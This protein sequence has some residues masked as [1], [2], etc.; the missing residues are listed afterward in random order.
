M[1]YSLHKT[2]PMNMIS[3]K[4][5]RAISLAYTEALKSDFRTFKLGAVVKQSKVCV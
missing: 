3:T 4:D 2:T 5:Q 1:L